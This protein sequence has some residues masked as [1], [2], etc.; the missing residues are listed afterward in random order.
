MSVD[1]TIP[2]AAEQCGGSPAGRL[3][4]VPVCLLPKASPN[5]MR[6]DFRDEAGSLPLPTREQNALAAYSALLWASS[7]ALNAAELIEGRSVPVNLRAELLFVAA[8]PQ[9]Y[10]DPVSQSILRPGIGIPRLPPVPEVPAVAA[11]DKALMDWCATLFD[12][13]PGAADADLFGGDTASPGQ[14]QRM[15][16]TL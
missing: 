10:A 2:R 9:E 4:L 3:Y 7:R 11:A 6:F 14:L 8:G 13:R 15:H 16:W 5:L 1:F 12:A